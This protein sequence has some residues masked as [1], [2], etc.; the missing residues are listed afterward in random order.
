M[1]DFT[2][3]IAALH[4][5]VCLEIRTRLHCVYIYIYIYRNYTIRKHALKAAFFSH[6]HQVLYFSFLFYAF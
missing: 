2:I 6:N 5:K 4:Y 3:D 1:I